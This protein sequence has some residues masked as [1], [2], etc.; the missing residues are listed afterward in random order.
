[1]GFSIFLYE[2]QFCVKNWN[3]LWNIAFYNDIII[4]NFKIEA[5]FKLKKEVGVEEK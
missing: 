5:I 4:I 2:K 3:L 1:M